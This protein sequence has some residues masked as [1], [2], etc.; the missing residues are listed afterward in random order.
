MVLYVS[1]QERHEA[2]MQVCY[3]IAIVQTSDR[4][5]FGEF[6]KTNVI[7]QYCSYPAKFQ[8]HS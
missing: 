4:E 5:N 3:R 7:H 1:G 8:I 2:Y 6:G